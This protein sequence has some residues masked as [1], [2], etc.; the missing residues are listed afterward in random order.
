MKVIMT[1][2]KKMWQTL[3][4]TDSLVVERAINLL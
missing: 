1:T 3:D 4:G 2:D